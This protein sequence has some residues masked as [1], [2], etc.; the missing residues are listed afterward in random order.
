MAWAT[1]DRRERLPPDWPRLRAQVLAEA[2]H[3]CENTK[4]DGRRCWDK[5]TEVDHIVAGD[6]HS[7][8]NL[9]AIC[10]WCHRRK[11]ALEGV[12]ARKA[13]DSILTR[14]PET[15]PGLVDPKNPLP[16]P[17]FKGF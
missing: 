9:R 8:S 5:A 7:R 15:H 16:P 10:T 13:A 1:S 4:K 12:E 14:P 3:R 6:D 2:G 11:S 17:Q